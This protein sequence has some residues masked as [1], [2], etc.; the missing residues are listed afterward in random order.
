MLMILMSRLAYIYSIIISSVVNFS[1]DRYVHTLQYVPRKRQ[2]PAIF[3]PL[4]V[5]RWWVANGELFKR[6]QYRLEIRFWNGFQGVLL[7]PGLPDG[8][9]SYKNTNLGIFWRVLRWQMLVYFMTIWYILWPFGIVCVH[10][11]NFFRFDLFGP[12]KIWQP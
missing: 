5:Q 11:I 6:A 2:I 1:S 12:R 4:C 9:F 8:L 7:W 3:K 10:L